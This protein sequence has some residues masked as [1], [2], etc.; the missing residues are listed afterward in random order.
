M[1]IESQLKGDGHAGRAVTAI[2]RGAADTL[3]TTG[4]DCRLVTW[5]LTAGAQ[6]AVSKIG[7]DLPTCVAYLPQSGRLLVGTRELTLWSPGTDASAAQCQQTFTGHSSNVCILKS[8]L[9]GDTEYV[10]STSK[11]DRTVSMWRCTAADQTAA[12]AVSAVGRN[13]VATFL[14]ADVAHYVS[15]AVTGDR[16]EVSAVTRSGVAHVF[17]VKDVNE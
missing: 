4:E 1:Q 16:L 11:M 6:S 10:L 9:V 13:A 8:L 14:M 7:A 15:T 3:Y 17:I 2:C 5:S 12:A